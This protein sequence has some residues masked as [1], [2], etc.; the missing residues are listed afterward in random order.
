MIPLFDNIPT[1]RFAYVTYALIAVNVA[2]FFYTWRMG[3]TQAADFILRWGYVPGDVAGVLTGNRFAPQE[4]VTLVTSIFL[5]GGLV[6]LAGN[7]LYLHIF[8]N[9]VEDS[10]GHGRFLGFYLLVGVAANLGQIVVSP[11]STV[12]G[13]G[14]SGAIAGILGAYF[15][16][17]PRAGVVTLVPVLFIPIFITVPAVVILGFWF[18]IQLFQG[19]VTI[20]AGTAGSGGVAFV[21]H[22]T[23]FVLGMILMPFFRNRELMRG[24]P[25][26]MDRVLG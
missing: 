17:F 25:T 6:H 18:V 20:A 1:R 7:L 9:N 2:V 23:G 13:V 3:G 21:V 26:W 8:G 12:P 16:L 15:L 24:K 22:A 11:D 14:A 19:S 10:M 4:L 5:H